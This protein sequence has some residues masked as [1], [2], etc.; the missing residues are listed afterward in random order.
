MKNL[1][2]LQHEDILKLEGRIIN[3]AK[4]ANFK[5]FFQHFYME[6]F[7]FLLDPIYERKKKLVY[8]EKLSSHANKF[9]EIGIEISHKEKWPRS[10]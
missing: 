6:T 10:Y 8:D 5:Y 7:D 9:Y 3:C 1:D 2:S 4:K